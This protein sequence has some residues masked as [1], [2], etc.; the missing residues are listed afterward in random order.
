MAVLTAPFAAARGDALAL[1]DDTGS[2]TWA[3]LDERVNRL[4]DGFRTAGIG[5]GDTI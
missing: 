1:A 5:P 4:I 2:R 3:E